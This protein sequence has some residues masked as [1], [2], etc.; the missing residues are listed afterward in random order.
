MA[1]A[2]KSANSEMGDKIKNVYN[3][4]Q[5]EYKKGRSAEEIKNMLDNKNESAKTSNVDKVKKSINNKK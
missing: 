3:Y 2:L 4:A 1:G 5:S